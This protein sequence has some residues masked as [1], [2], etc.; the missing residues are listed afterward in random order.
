MSRISSE[1][2]RGFKIVF[3]S[4]GRIFIL[5]HKFVNVYCVFTRVV[6]FM[7]GIVQNMFGVH[8]RTIHA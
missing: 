5:Q 4:K 2:K 7:I 3:L 1:L 8:L 6:I